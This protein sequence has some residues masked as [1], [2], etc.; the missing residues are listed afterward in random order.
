MLYDIIYYAVQL[1]IILCDISSLGVFKLLHLVHSYIEGH[2]DSVSH[3]VCG[4]RG[5][6][7]GVAPHGDLINVKMSLF[8]HRISVL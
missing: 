7:S 3:G 1:H 5:Y 6:C 8:L 2:R 4:F